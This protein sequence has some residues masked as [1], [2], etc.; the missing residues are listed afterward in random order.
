MTVHTLQ[1]VP[2]GSLRCF[3]GTPDHLTANYPQNQTEA[4]HGSGRP[5]GRRNALHKSP[6]DKTV[7][8]RIQ[9]SMSSQQCS[10]A[11]R[12]CIALVRT[13]QM[14]PQTFQNTTKH[15]SAFLAQSQIP[16][17][18]ANLLAGSD[19]MFLTKK[20][21]ARLITGRLC[22]GQHYSAEPLSNGLCGCVAA[23]KRRTGGETQHRRA[24]FSVVGDEF[25][26]TPAP[27]PQPWLNDSK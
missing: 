8:T 27:V 26:Y 19:V 12:G 16:F 2:D 25:F 5:S 17:F 15:F 23:S 4:A 3:N 24:D 1:S 9:G 6:I 18:G 14:N 20:E 11:V 13:S 21:E 22:K 7:D 10:E